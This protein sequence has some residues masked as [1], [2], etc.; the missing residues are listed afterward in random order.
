VTGTPS[1]LVK[2]SWVGTLHILTHIPTQLLL[3]RY[4]IFSQTHQ[5]TP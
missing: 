3:S 4:L 2:K 1:E 5:Q